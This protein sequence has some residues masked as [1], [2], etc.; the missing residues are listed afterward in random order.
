M[1]PRRVTRARHVMVYGPPAAGKLTVASAFADATGYRLL[2]NHLTVDL[3]LR[4]FEWGT[5]PHAQLVTTMRLALFRAAA[6]EGVDVVSTF[7]YA[8]SVD[9]A[10][11]GEVTDVIHEHGGEL[12]FVQLRPPPDVLEAR[13]TLESR[14]TRQKLHDVQGLRDLLERY[15]CY[16][17]I[18]GTVLSIDN[19]DQSATE[20]AGKIRSHLGI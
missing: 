3:A 17:T 5:A 1:S 4:L 13:V 20:V 11:V 6:T 18:E 16:G 14:A 2:D 7:V 9:D 10:Y 8:T 19:T 12:F 15:D